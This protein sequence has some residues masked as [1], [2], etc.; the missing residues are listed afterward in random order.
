MRDPVSLRDIGMFFI[1]NIFYS[2]VV[3]RSRVHVFAVPRDDTYL[4]AF[5]RV[6]AY[7]F[8]GMQRIPAF[9]LTTRT[10]CFSRSNAFCPLG[11]GLANILNKPG[12]SL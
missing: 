11:R 4:L 9:G 6:L 8:P 3:T 2:L 5:W 10:N 7:N 1:Q 12:C